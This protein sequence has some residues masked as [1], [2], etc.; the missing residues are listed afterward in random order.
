MFY[1]VT[2]VKHYVNIAFLY[3]LQ[4]QPLGNLIVVRSLLVEPSETTL[5]CM[6]RGS[7]WDF[8]DSFCVLVVTVCS[9]YLN[10]SLWKKVRNN[11]KF[12]E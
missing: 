2:N 7:P 12:L 11:E 3:M 4:K 10:D 1:Y 5:H 6:V 9:V 8:S